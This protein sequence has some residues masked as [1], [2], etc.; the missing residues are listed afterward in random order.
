M[1][2]EWINEDRDRKKGKRYQINYKLTIQIKWIY[3]KKYV[4]QPNRIA[5][6]LAWSTAINQWSTRVAIQSEL[7]KS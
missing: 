1:N 2:N 6:A 5:S 4:L 3:L 7:R